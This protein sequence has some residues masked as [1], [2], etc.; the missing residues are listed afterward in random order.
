MTI[1]QVAQ[2]FK[3]SKVTIYKWIDLKIIPPT[4]KIGGRCYFRTSQIMGMIEKGDIS[5]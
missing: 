1:K 4:I 2:L 5:R 3:V